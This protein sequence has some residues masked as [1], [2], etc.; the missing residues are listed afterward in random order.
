VVVDPDAVTEARCRRRAEAGHGR[1]YFAKTESSR[2][3]NVQRA[4]VD[5]ELAELSVVLA[6]LGAGWMGLGSPAGLW[7]GS[8][9]AA[10]RDRVVRHVG[11]GD[12]EVI[13]FGIAEVGRAAG[14]ELG[15]DRL[16][17]HAGARGAHLSGE[18]VDLFGSVDHDPDGEPDASAA[19]LWF[20]VPVTGQLGDREQCQDDA[21][22]FE[23]R[24][25]F[26]IDEL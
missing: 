18:L 22:D 21:T 25:L 23:C 19:R 4:A 12:L 3:L 26:V 7:S 16:L 20:G 15:I 10:R 11:P 6:L 5:C 24:E 8:D 9:G 2:F 1:C 13:A 14:E 17:G